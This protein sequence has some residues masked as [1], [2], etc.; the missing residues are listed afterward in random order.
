[1]QPNQTKSW[2]D[3]PSTLDR[4]F[5][6]ARDE[7]KTDCNA[8]R[9]YK[10]LRYS[11][12]TGS[13][14]SANVHS[15]Y[16]GNLDAF[17]ALSKKVGFNVSEEVTDACTA[18]ICQPLRPRTI[19][20]AAKP[21]IAR[22]CTILNRLQDGVID[23][24][25]F[26]QEA[27]M[28]WEDSYDSH[29]NG[30]VF[31]EVNHET[32]TITSR[33]INSAYVYYLVCE[34]RNPVHL[35]FEEAM[36]REVANEMF[37]GFENEI[38][39]A[40]RWREESIPGVDPSDGGTEWDT[41]CVRRAWRRRTG[42]E[43]GRFVVSI[44]GHVVNGKPKDKG[45]RT[46]EAWDYDFFPFAVF[47][48]KRDNKGFGSVPMMKTIAPYH[49]VIN[50][51]ARLI[52]DSFKGAVPVISSHQQSSFD[53]MTD[54][55]YQIFKWKGTVEPKIHATNPVSEQLLRERNFLY[56]KA[57][58]SVG[59][60]RSLSQG[61]A[62]KGVV[63]AV[64]M[65]ETIGLAD[66]RA[67]EYQKNW[68]SGWRQAGH[69]IVA[70][71][72]EL[73][74]M[75]I[76]STDANAEM[77]EE[78]DLSGLKVN[79]DDYKITFGLTSALSKSVHGLM[80]DL[81]EFKDA[82]LIDLVTMAQAIGDKVPDVQAD[83]DRITAHYRLAAKQVQDAIEKGTIPVVPGAR[84]GKNSLD[85]IVVLGTQAWCS[86]LINPDRYPPEN[87]EMLRRLIKIA[88]S[89]KAGPAPTLQLGTPG[90]AIAP[91]ALTT[92]GAPAPQPVQPI[93]PQV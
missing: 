11:R 18:K 20:V 15:E 68:E 30:Y 3:D 53:G 49:I 65:R 31:F 16:L 23:S 92:I 78:L 93:Q 46:G 7:R 63:A 86:A 69:I 82:G 32:K 14:N 87:L 83:V 24:S 79:R 2:E 90:Q 74:K 39:A 13:V 34:G 91:G 41:I 89:K 75:K 48:N 64:A 36:S 72:C 66:A 22:A 6:A 67:A 62:P 54:A 25:G 70:F 60:N 85:A 26:L 33:R 76:A 19:P 37:P 35:Y 77:M 43:P 71:A 42:K 51:Y 55:P 57:Y 88:E 8:M 28:A 29:T 73:K 56:D 21:D 1:M 50:E 58:E 59:I 10:Q 84:Q 80:S 38:A 12:P 9:K 61:Q 40:P 45:E 17:M 27:T 52:K 4:H 47:R 81:G 44:A 5:E